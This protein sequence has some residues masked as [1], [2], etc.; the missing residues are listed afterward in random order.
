MYT[1]S[2]S[3]ASNEMSEPKGSNLWMY[4]KLVRD[5]AAR[6]QDFIQYPPVDPTR[7]DGESVIE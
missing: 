2:Q 1:K 7:Y 4:E 3:Q 5:M 6:H